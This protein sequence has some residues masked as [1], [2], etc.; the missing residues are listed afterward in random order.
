MGQALTSLS[1]P[2][3][4]KIGGSLKLVACPKLTRIGTPTLSSI[5]NPTARHVAKQARQ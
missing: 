5:G 2:N 3:L 1:M 4:R